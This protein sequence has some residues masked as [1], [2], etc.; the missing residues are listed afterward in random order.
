MSTSNPTQ[1]LP[2]RRDLDVKGESDDGI[3]HRALRG[4]ELGGFNEQ[5]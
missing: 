5:P 3:G 4:H 1:M 2:H